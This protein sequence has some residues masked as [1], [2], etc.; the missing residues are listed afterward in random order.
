LEAFA[1]QAALVLDRQ[2]LHD[3]AQFTRLAAESERLGK[4]LL[5]SIS[6]EMRTPIAAITSAASA[7]GDANLTAQPEFTG[8]VAGEIR[9]AAARLNRLV[10]NLLDSA[11]VESG[12]VTP[13][14][15]WCDVGDLINVTLKSVA[16]ELAGHKL[17]VVIKPEIPFVRMDFALMEQALTNLALNAAFHTP[18]GTEVELGAEREKDELKLTVADRGRGIPAEA[19]PKLFA[20]F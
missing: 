1:R 13:K 15:D 4:T 6:H 14:M 2:R 16:K 12:H 5:D 9:E 3:A 11:R 17:S 19:L 20:R 10:G 7:L 18:T 8:A